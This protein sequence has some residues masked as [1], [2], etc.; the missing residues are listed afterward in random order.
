MDYYLY[1]ND[2]NIGPLPETEVVGGLRNGRFARNDLGCRVGDSD[3]KDLS[4]FFPLETSAPAQPT[5]PVYQ[6]P[7]PVL[8]RQ[9]ISQAQQLAV[10][11]NQ[12]PQRQS[13]S[14]F[15]LAGNP[16][17]NGDY[18]LGARFLALLVDNICGIP[19]FILA[20]IP[21]VGIV[22]SPL[23]CLYFISRDSIFGGQSIGK[24]IMG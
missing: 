18:Q 20:A 2:Q 23:L 16:Y 12:Q 6:Q 13:A 5:Q 9:P 8:Y 14:N 24:K 19:L 4:F 3:W 7:T 17:Q 15:S 10:I 22:G 21:F 1:K 11:S